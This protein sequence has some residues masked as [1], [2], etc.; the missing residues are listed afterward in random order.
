MP[1]IINEDQ[2]F[3]A[4]IALLIARGYDRTT[5]SEMA[6]AA[7]MHEATLFR[8]Y[9]SKVGLIEQ[10]IEH[11]LSATPMSKVSY[12]GDLRADLI[13]ILEAYMATV[14]THGEIM[15]M[16]LLEIP[17]HPELKSTVQTPLANIR[18]I[19]HI[20]DRYQKEGLLKKEPSLAS[21]NALLAPLMVNEMYRRVIG[22]LLTPTLDLQEYADAFLY[23]RKP[24]SL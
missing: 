12:S 9:G 5:T 17:R 16:I 6:A 7:N 20:L 11:Q 4:V 18:G 21:V 23:G 22:D 8:K 2:V 19:T 1:K 13:R 15:P 3:K 10:A 24:Q 14:E